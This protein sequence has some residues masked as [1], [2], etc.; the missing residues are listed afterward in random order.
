MDQLIQD[1]DA[2]MDKYDPD[3]KV[4]LI[5]DEWGIWTNVEPGTNPGFLYQQN[6]LRDA[7]IAALNFHIFH[8]HADRVHMANIAQ[9]V[10]VLQAM[11]LTDGP[12]MLRTPTYWTFEMF[13]VH[14]GEDNLELNVDCGTVGVG[15][16]QIPVISASASRD[17]KTGVVHLSLVNTHPGKAIA[18]DADLGNI[19]PKTV[20][21]RVLTA[22]AVDAHNTFEQPDQV[23]PVEFSG[24]SMNGS[25]V[26]VIMPAK[27]V[28]VL[29]F[30]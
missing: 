26:S 30:K 20:Q 13:K 25:K 16:S 5:V 11:I 14:Q 7:I 2:I 24:A 18:V 8:R 3:Q 9:M 15:D 4:G 1:H 17:S 28:V 23:S 22:D 29:T 6:S 12:R 19:K 10:N 21:G 27:S